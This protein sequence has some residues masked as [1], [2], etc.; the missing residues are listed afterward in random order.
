MST[1]V[2]PATCQCGSIGRTDLRQC[3]EHFHLWDGD[4]RLTSVRRIIEMCWPQKPCQC[5]ATSYKTH[6]PDCEVYARILNAQERGKEVEDLFTQYVMERRLRIPSGSKRQDAVALVRKLCAWFDDNDFQ[7]VRC[8]VVVGSGD[9]GG[10]ADFVFDDHVFELKATY[11]LEETHIMQCTGYATLLNTNGSVLHVTERY[12][13]VREREI[14]GQDA[15]DWAIML[16]YWRM[17]QR[18]IK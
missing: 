6:K 7:D 5:G 14:S 4:R 11:A 3:P 1:T 13:T 16:N 10:V 2:I 12:P 9:H 18:R 15:S 8:Q 17:L